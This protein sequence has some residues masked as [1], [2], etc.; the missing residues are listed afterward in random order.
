[1][2]RACIE[3]CIPC[4]TACTCAQPEDG[5]F[6]ASLAETLHIGTLLMV[7]IG[8]RTQRLRVFM[9]SLEV[10]GCSQMLA[11]ARQRARRSAAGRLT[12]SPVCVCP[13]HALFRSWRCSSIAPALGCGTPCRTLP[14]RPS[15]YGLCGSYPRARALTL[16]ARAQGVVCFI[17]SFVM[18]SVARQ[19]WRW[20]KKKPQDLAWPVK[21]FLATMLP[22]SYVPVADFCIKCMSPN[23]FSRSR[24]AVG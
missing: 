23:T 6:V 12:R 14:S 17:G 8:S 20:Y 2:Q 16:R 9:L 19:A 7:P 4:F 10:R 1:M 21:A 11:M 22:M 15:A 5:R 24:D 3:L 18:L 13:G